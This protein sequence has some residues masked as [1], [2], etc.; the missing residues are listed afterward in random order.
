M[1]F[2]AHLRY[3]WMENLF[4]KPVKTLGVMILGGFEPEMAFI[5]HFIAISIG[6]LNHSNLKISWGPLKYLFNNP[7]MH[8]YHHAYELPKNGFGVNFGISLSAWDYLFQLDYIPESGGNVKIGFPGDD[9]VPSRF[10]AQLFYGFR[11]PKK[12]P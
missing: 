5:V 3:H 12:T 8:L 6:H 10:W 9:Q 2:A 11:D 7:I 1:G 4:Y